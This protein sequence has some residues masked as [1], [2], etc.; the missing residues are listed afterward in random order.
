MSAAEK[1]LY[2]DL[3]W[4]EVNEAVALGKVILLPVGSTEQHGRHL[5][6]DVDNLLATGVCLEAG[7][8]QP[9]RILVAPT[10]PYGFNIHAMDFPGTV[11]VAY[12]HFVEFCL[13][14]VKSFAYHGFKRIVIVDGHGSNEHLLEFVGRRAVLETDALVASFMWWNMLRVDPGFLPSVRDSAF[15]GGAAHACE[16]ETSLYLHLCPE[17]VQMDKAEDQITFHNSQGATGFRWFDAFGAGPVRL[18]EWTSS[19]T[20]SGVVGQPTLA[21]AEKGRRILDEAVR[22]LLDWVTEFQAYQGAARASHHAAPP[23]SPLPPT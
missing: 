20:P 3:T 9:E 7:R 5:P 2:A 10:I 11:H 16:I 13:D 12:D 23:T 4:P 8:R 6:L 15:P 14:V 18:V 21:T 17:K 19:Y 1:Y 22:H